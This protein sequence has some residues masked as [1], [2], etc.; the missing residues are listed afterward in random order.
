MAPRVVSWLS[1]PSLL[2]TLVSHLRLSVR[3]LREPGVPLLLKAL[4]AV[5]AIY[6]ISPFDFVPDVLPI[7]GQIDDLGMIVIALQAFVKLCP[8]GAVDFHRAAMAERR[9]YYPM[10]ST[11]EVIDAEFRRE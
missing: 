3:L 7:I 1:R 11:G 5:A 2:R 8:T 9:K 6:V 4:P 10:P